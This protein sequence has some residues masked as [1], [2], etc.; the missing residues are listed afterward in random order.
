M[1]KRRSR[2]APSASCARRPAAS[3]GTL[4]PVEA[5]AD[6]AWRKGLYLHVDGAFG[7][8]IL[9]FMRDL[10]YEIPPFDLSVKGV[11]RS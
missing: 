10:G 6:L 3:F 5:F 11:A 4:D 1:S 8:F 2:R 7:G 9:P